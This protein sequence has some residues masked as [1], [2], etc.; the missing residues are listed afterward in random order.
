[1]KTIFGLMFIAVTIILLFAI[2]SLVSKDKGD[3]KGME[4]FI[5]IASMITMIEISMEY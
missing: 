4:V 5:I 1:M 3:E 2:I